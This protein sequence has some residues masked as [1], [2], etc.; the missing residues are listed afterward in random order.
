MACKRT[1][2]VVDYQDRFEV[3]LPCTGKLTKEQRVQIF[4]VG[5]QPPLS[6]DVE[7]HSP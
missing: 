3:L 1:G 7:I 6:L 2:S 5:L 4:T